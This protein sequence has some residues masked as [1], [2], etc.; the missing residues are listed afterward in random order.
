[1]GKQRLLNEKIQPPGGVGVGHQIV[2]QR[3][4][5]RAHGPADLHLL[6]VLL[7]ADAHP[8]LPQIVLLRVSLGPVQLLLHLLLGGADLPQL[9]RGGIGDV[10]APAAGV[11]RVQNG[12]SRS[13]IMK[14]QARESRRIP[15]PL[16]HGPQGLQPLEIALELKQLHMVR[17]LQLPAPAQ[18]AADVL[19]LAQH[20]TDLVVQV[21]QLLRMGGGPLH[22]VQLQLQLLPLVGGIVPQA[23]NALLAKGAAPMETL[24]NILQADFFSFLETDLDHASSSFTLITGTS[25]ASRIRAMNSSLSNFHP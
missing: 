13:G 22:I 9:R 1:M 19:H 8:L 10:K 25:T 12:Q 2:G 23:A 18:G 4:Q 24:Q 5:G 21:L 14:F 16:K 11:F 20:H 6:A 17:H 3:S 15:Q 7:G